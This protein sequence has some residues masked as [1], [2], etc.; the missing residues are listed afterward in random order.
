MLSE[1]IDQFIYIGPTFRRGGLKT[2]SIFRGG[3][4][5]NVVDLIREYP[6]LQELFV[7]PANLPKKRF[8]LRLKNSRTSLIFESVK[9]WINDRAR[10][11]QSNNQ[12][13]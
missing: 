1:K 4:P 9:K 8:E 2:G 13:S 11:M 6:P 10:K 7:A 12:S 5:Q 3:L